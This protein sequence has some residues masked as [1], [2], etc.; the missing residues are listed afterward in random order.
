[1]PFTDRGD[2]GR[3]LA[4]AL[5]AYRDR[6]PIVLGL[7]RGGVA[8]AA[9]VAARLGAPLDALVVRKLSSPDNPEFAFGAVAEG[10]VCII[11]DDTCDALGIGDHLRD[12][13][14][15]EAHE[16]VRGRV[17]FLR[18]G[19][20]LADLSGRVVIV[21]DDGLATGSTAAAGVGAARAMGARTVVVAVPVGSAEA[22]RRL[23]RIADEVVCLETPL[24]FRAVG[25]WFDD[26]S[27]VPDEA[28]RRLL[29]GS[30]G[31]QGSR[32]LEVE[33]PIPSTAG[34]GVRLPGILDIP[35]RAHGLVVF[36]HGSG[37]SR[38][39]PRNQRVARSL[40]C[41]SM[42]T[43]LFDLL[44]RDD[45]GDR[46]LI[47]DIDYLGR[48]LIHAIDW[49]R[50]VDEVR[51]LPIGLFGASTGAAAALV[52]AAEAPGTVQSVVS[53]GGRPDLAADWLPRVMAPTLLIVG[54]RDI[55]VLRLNRWAAQRLGGP[56]ELAV[57]E[58]ATHLFEEP[59]A[60]D[61]VCGLAKAW[62]TQTLRPAARVGDRR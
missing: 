44:A 59:G 35:P 47:F 37:S 38:L 60:L 42:A 45:D 58:H 2:A 9:E 41:A 32:A 21:V 57:V 7:P 51:G 34:P 11:D 20:R 24:D 62:F 8:A 19:K 36:A 5:D 22:V 18:Q 27:P 33:V 6:A 61:Q 52:A 26:F 4:V 10:G 43:L 53:R 31:S 40:V 16:H 49:V 54:G 14:V 55:D 3:R 29:A 56:H 30:Q 13:I 15:T 23:R 48:R 17:D 46:R 28:V 1:M 39:S 25:E 50:E 12:R